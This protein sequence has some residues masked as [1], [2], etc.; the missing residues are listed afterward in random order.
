MIQC[1]AAF[2]TK[3]KVLFQVCFRRDCFIS[4]LFQRF[5]LYVKQNAGTNLK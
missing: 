4:V 3:M 5:V 1:K 2:T